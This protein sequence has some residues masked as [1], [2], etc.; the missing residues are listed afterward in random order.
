MMPMPAGGPP[1][2]GEGGGAPQGAPDPEMIK[3][4]IVKMLMEAKRVA[5][6]AGLDWAEVL[7]SVQGPSVK[8]APKMPPP[9]AGM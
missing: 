4:E 1:M 6:Q 3:A 8:P 9:Q 2:G 5:Q 7:S